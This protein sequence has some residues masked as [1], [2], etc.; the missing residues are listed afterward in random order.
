M[1]DRLRC[2]RQFMIHERLLSTESCCDPRH[3]GPE[4]R[5]AL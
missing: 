5:L 4:Q 2:P 1:A 3:Q